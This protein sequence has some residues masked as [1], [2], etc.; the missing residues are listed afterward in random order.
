M[1][2]DSSTPARILL[3]DDDALMR[4]SLKLLLGEHYE[5][6]VVEAAAALSAIQQQVPDLILADALM[7]L[8]ALALLQALRADPQTQEVPVILLSTP[9]EEQACIEG[10]E[11]GADDYIIK[12]F[13]ERELLARIK[14]KLRMARLHRTAAHCEQELHIQAEAAEANLSSILSCIKDQF[15]FLDREWRYTYVNDRVVEVVGLPRE[16]LLGKSIWQVFPDII[17][18][19]F[20]TQAHRALAE[21]TAVQFEYYYPRLQRWFENHI[22]P[23]E[24]GVSILVTDITERQL[25]EIALRSSE[26]FNRQIF[27][28]IADCVKV[29]DTDGRLL[30]MNTPGL[31]L[32]EIDDLTRLIGCQWLEWWEGE[33]SE[34]A[35]A[36]M[37]SARAGGTGRFQGSC[38]TAKGTPKWWDVLVTPI[39]DVQGKV[40]RLLSVSRDIT[41]QKRNEA[42]LAALKEQLTT[43]LADMTRLHSLS[44][45]LLQDRELE[46]LLQEILE[47]AMLQQGA[48]QGAIALLQADM[49]NLQIYDQQEPSLKIVAQFG[50]KQEFLDFCSAT[51][52]EALCGISMRERRRVIVGDI[53]TDPRFEHLRLI[54]EK[55][56]YRAVQSTPLFGH[57]GEILGVLSTHFRHPHRPSERELRL[58]DLY[59]RQAAQ[60]IERKQAEQRLQIYVDVVRNTQ[61]G[62]VVW[63]LENLND[64]G[65]FRLLVGNPAAL[66]ATGI[67]FEQLIGTTMAES[68]PMLLQTPL[69]QQY[70]EVIRT[71]LALDLGEVPYSEDGITAGIYSLKA[72]PLPNHCLGLAFENITAR[73]QTEAQLQQSQRFV[74]QIAETMPGVLFVYDLIEQRNIYINCQIT[75]LLGYTPEQIQAM[76]SDVVATLTH[77]DDLADLS[78]YLEEFHSAP[79]GVVRAIEYRNRHANGEWRWLYIQ[80]LV[81]NRTANGIPRQILGVAINITKRKQAEQALRDAHVQL[82]SALVA[83]AVYTWKWQIPGDRIIVNAA[84]AHLFAVDPVGA[85]TEGLPLEIFL[86]AIHEEDRPHIVAAI[87][88]AIETGEEYI[89]EYRVHT[90]TGDERWVVARGRVE[91]DAAGKPVAF[92]G[93][94]ADITERKR[95]QED[96]DR[97]FQLSRDMLAILNTDG[98]FLQ[99][100]P[101][102]TETLGYTSQELT[103]QPYIEFVHPDDQAKTLVE[104]QKLA[105]GIPTIAF[106]NR[107]RCRDGSY[108]WI[109]WSI[110][111]FVEQK[112][113][114]CVARDI[115]ERKSAEVE[116]ERLLAREQAARETAEAANRVKDEFLAV[117]SHELRTPLN[118][119]LGWSQLLQNRKLDEKRTSYA[120]ETIERNAKLQV[121]LIDDLLDVSRILQGKLS[122]NVTPVNLTTT[123]TAALETVRLAAQAKSIQ[124]QTALEPNIGQ[125]LGDSGRLQQVIWNL[126]SNAV[127]FTPQ[128]G[129]VDIWLERLD[130][131]AQ[132]T[133]SDTGKGI[134]TD[135]LPHVFEYFRQADNATTRQFGGL[136]LGLAIVRQIVELHG[137]TVFAESKGVD[138]GATFTVRLP[139]M[140]HQSEMPQQMKASEPS[141]G[142]QGIKVLVVDDTA[143]M[144]EYVT[145]V[146]EQSGAK[147]IAVASAAEALAVLAEFQPAVL[148]SDIGMAEM[149][150]YMLMR[151]VRSLPPE[152]GGRIPAI[153]LSAYAGEINQQQAIAAGFER[154]ISKPVEP[155]ALVAVILDLLNF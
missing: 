5:V 30:M 143:D 90:A 122:L 6:I 106:E 14:T 141:L 96:C 13:S 98:Y 75:D 118:P 137:G 134:H 119:I 89:A 94:L 73:K 76:G 45:Q 112:L 148:I 16:E 61:V 102:W 49:G 9:G 39:L 50:F 34:A 22:Y 19:Q 107:Y 105:Q 81:F 87:K 128:G 60:L 53:Q 133:V 10:L 54:A 72:F 68:F 78:A 59:A 154:H 88:R 129:R 3:V 28:S 131:Q 40:V 152:Q 85:A 26:E 115:T 7:P 42:E 97:F 4:D 65:S 150:G 38:C 108:R 130:A 101:A 139:L 25:A 126:V 57:S 110:A 95:A 93:A 58:L 92:P 12:P 43:E 15:L 116:M 145:F 125:V 37:A 71:G 20:Y 114:Y 155:A 56:G 52:E 21:Q 103:T 1:G 136:G 109:L 82:E 146:L 79:E 31:S 100:S 135:F 36:A 123:I 66:K 11:A 138:Q 120:L 99:A 86:R 32:V 69:V 18:S 147:V 2:N 55:A 140:Q 124:I 27:D 23:S 51:A 84:F 77:P 24:N 47:A 113:L 17:N 70:A 41:E 29:L 121:Q 80:C 91:Y 44:T 62:I 127:K 35:H 74:E 132:I 83:G 153:A 117:L 63:Q 151:Q 142:L 104:A 8:D 48:A 33:Y 46:P 144:R 64:P 67:N 111:P 149:D